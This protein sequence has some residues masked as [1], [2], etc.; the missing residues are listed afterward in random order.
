M[1]GTPA[2]VEAYAVEEAVNMIRNNECGVFSP[3]IMECFDMA[4]SDFFQATEVKFSYAD[5]GE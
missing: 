4:K 5:A 3:K 2:F 1:A